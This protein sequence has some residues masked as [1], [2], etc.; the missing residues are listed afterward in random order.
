MNGDIITYGA[1]GLAFIAITAVGLVF[2]GGDRG[3]QSKRMKAIS[4]GSSS[5]GRAADAGAARRKQMADATKALRDREEATRKKRTV[6]RTIED[7]IKQAGLE[8]PISTF[9]IASAVIGVLAAG[10]TFFAGFNKDFQILVCA[11]IGFAA[12]F[13]VPRW[14]LSAA[15]KGR[16]KKFIT[17]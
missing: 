10:G 14:A 5:R 4:D 16:Q 3:K 6:G 17:S 7:R 2:A 12:A 8:I 11:G 9:W 15:I 13:G 1:T